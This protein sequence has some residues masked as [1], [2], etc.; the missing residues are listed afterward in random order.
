MES[1][2]IPEV[3]NPTNMKRTSPV[4]A[5]NAFTLCGM[6]AVA[7][8]N[9]FSQST[10]KDVS[11]KGKVE[12]FDF[13]DLEWTDKIPDCPVYRPS[14]MEFEDPLIYLQNIAPEASKYGICKIISPINASVPASVVLKKETRNFKFETY[15]QPLRLAQWNMN[16]K[17]SFLRRGRKYTYRDFEIKANKVYARR[18]SNSSCNPPAYMEKVFWHEMAHGQKGTVEYGVNVDGSA[19]SCDPNDQLGKSKWNLK[20]ISRLHNSIL[21]L[22]DRVI[23][24]ITDPMLYIGMLFGMFAW[25]VEDHYLY[26]INYH[27]SGAPKTWYGVPGHAA[28][29]F[30]RVVHDN[31]YSRDILSANEEDNVFEIIQEKTTM[32]PPSILLQHNVPVYKAVQMPGEFVITFPRAY[33][34]GFSHGFNCGEAVNFATGDWFPMGALASQRYALL[35][36][37]PI[38]PYEELLCNE[39]ML[40]FKS[41]KKENSSTSFEDSASQRSVKFSF[42]A[43]SASVTVTWHTSCATAAALIPSAFFMQWKMQLKNLKQEEEISLEL[44]KETEFGDDMFQQSSKYSSINDGFSPYCEVRFESKL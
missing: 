40:L 7:D 16:D 26:S 27:H 18:F 38:I 2:I 15:V 24:G 33:H 29:Q 42:D 6:E 5:T 4:K 31:V 44:Q 14:K 10:A 34:A 30:E 39:A 28:L 32:F 41:L 23:P 36:K 20:N 13:R 43:A 1:R 22:V 21:R 19:F 3:T 8:K 25:H 17:V 37:I 11:P 9:S 12:K 35:N